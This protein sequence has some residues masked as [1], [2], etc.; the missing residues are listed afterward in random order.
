M[1]KFT[2][3]KDNAFTSG[4]EDVDEAKE[5]KIMKRQKHNVDKRQSFESDRINEK[6]L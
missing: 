2:V 5:R 3:H 6:N 4:S 1:D